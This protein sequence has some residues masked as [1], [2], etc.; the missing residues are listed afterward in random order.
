MTC[1]WITNAACGERVT[2]AEVHRERRGAHEEIHHAVADGRREDGHH[3][4]GLAQ[5]LADRPTRREPLLASI[6][7]GKR[8]C[9]IRAATISAKTASA[10]NEAR[11]SGV[12]R[13]RVYASHQGPMKPPTMPPAKG[14]RDRP[15]LVVRR[16]HVGGGEAVVLA[17]GVVDAGRRT[18]RRAGGEAVPVGSRARRRRRPRCRRSRRA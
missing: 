18:F 13:V 8:S 2:A 14:E 11:N 3:D 15:A 10:T 4:G 1:H 9:R 5:D 12:V 16:R 7:G 6:C 17:E